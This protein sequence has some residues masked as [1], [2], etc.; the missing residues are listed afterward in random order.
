MRKTIIGA[1]GLATLCAPSAM[2]ANIAGES[3]TLRALDKVTA[4]TRDFTVKIGDTLNYGTLDIYVAHCE[5]RPPEETP[6]TYAFV[7]ISDRGLTAKIEDGEE[8]APKLFSGWMFGSNPA[9][10]ALDH[11]VYDI[12]PLACNAPPQAEDED[13]F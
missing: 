10:S 5:S 3:V 9:L 12:W 7:Q 13:E 8:P 11:P 6:E 4:D 2:A 1:I